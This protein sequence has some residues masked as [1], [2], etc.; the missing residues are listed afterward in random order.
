MSIS[1]KIKSEGRARKA[2][3]VAPSDND[4]QGSSAAVKMGSPA[5]PHHPAPKAEKPKKK[6][7]A[8][9]VKKRAP[10][11]KAEGMFNY[12]FMIISRHI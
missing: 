7:T 11:P 6:G 3:S 1:E 5:T 2:P 12:H 4:A 8:A 10:K 9:P